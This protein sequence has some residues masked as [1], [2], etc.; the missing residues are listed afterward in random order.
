MSEQV[1]KGGLSFLRYIQLNGYFLRR[2]IK[3]PKVRKIEMRK[4]NAFREAVIEKVEGEV[5]THDEAIPRNVGQ[6]GPDGPSPL[7]EQQ[8]QQ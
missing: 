5:E 1:Y 3:D 6:I 8:Q 4:I 2:V 7:E